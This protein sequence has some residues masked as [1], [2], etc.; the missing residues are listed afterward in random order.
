M[1]L[2]VGDRLASHLDLTWSSVCR[3]TELVPERGA[4][5][6]VRGAQIAIFRLSDDSVYAV[7]QR[8]P[9]SDAHVMSRGIVGSRGGAPTVASPMYKQVFDLRDGRCLD[10]VG[11]EPLDLVS[12]AVDVTDG[13]VR[14]SLP[15]RV[16]PQPDSPT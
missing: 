5:A 8:D 7:Q 10:P 11:L 9:F 13:V 1:T 6:L 4:A 16:A 15:E 14:V 2:D 12:Y 3:L